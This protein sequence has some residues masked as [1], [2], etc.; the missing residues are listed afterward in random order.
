M[1]IIDLRKINITANAVESFEFSKTKKSVSNLRTKVEKM[2]STLFWS[3]QAVIFGTFH[4][5]RVNNYGNE[6]AI[7]IR[8][9][10][11]LSSGVILVHD[12]ACPYIA[13]LTK[14]NVQGLSWKLLGH[15]FNSDCLFVRY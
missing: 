9:C 3:G 14:K 13:T 1:D 12:N 15:P 8:R 5:P 2:L 4:G 10:G 11:Q 6:K 7:K